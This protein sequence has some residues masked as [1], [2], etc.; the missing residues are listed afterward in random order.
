MIY[1]A[2]PYSDEDP[3]IMEFRF[4]AVCEAA[5]KLM[6]KGINVFSPIAHTHP[7]A[8]YGLPKGFDFW[9]RYDEWFLQHCNEM[10]ILL[11]D[12][13]GSSKGIH[14]ERKIM[15]QLG[16]PVRFV[17]VDGEIKSGSVA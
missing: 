3:E 6:L 12:G 1:L 5:S 2:S 7:I 13:W 11:I 9:E 4:Q 16:K 10:L 14:E 15:N 17:T 8:Q